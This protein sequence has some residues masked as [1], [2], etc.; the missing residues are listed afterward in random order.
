MDLHEAGDRL[1]ACKGA[2]KPVGLTLKRTNKKYRKDNGELM[3]IHCCDECG[4]VSINRIAADDIAEHIYEIYEK[5][6][7]VG[8]QLK[9]SIEK[10]SI[11]MLRGDDCDLVRARL[12][13]G[14]THP[15]YEPAYE[16][17]EAWA[18]G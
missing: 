18:N 3:L 9:T 13:G 17:F 1:S 5:S 11:H 8:L 2:M 14:F 15:V 4:K 10:N 16:S 6:G 7:K 12:F